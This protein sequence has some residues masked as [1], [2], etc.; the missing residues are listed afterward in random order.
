MKRVIYI[1]LPV[2]L[3][4]S[5]VFGQKNK[6]ANRPKSLN[7]RTEFIFNDTVVTNQSG[8]K[9]INLS[10]KTKYTDY[11]IFSFLKDT[12]YVDTSLTIEKH[13]AFN[14]LR[15]DHFGLLP[16]HNV[17]QTFNRMTYDFNQIR[18]IPDIGFTAKQFFFKTTEDIRY[19]EV[20]TPTSEIMFLTTLEQGQFLNSFFTLNFSR[21]MNA[22]IAYTGLRSLGKYRESLVSQGN[23]RTTFHYETKKRTYQVRGHLSTYDN[24]NEESG[25]LTTEALEA[26]IENDL[27]FSDRARLDVNLDETENFFKSSRFFFEHDFK[28]LSFKDSMEQKKFTILKIG[29]LFTSEKK[30]YEFRQNS[31]TDFIGSSNFSGSINDG[32]KNSLLRNTFFLEL[33]SKHILG[34]LRVK[35]SQMR[36][37]YGYDQIKDQNS[38][39][40]NPRLRGKATSLGAE[41]N[42]RVKQFELTADGEVIPGVDRL[43]GNNLSANVSYKRDSSFQ[44]KASVILNSKSP[45]FNFLLHQ[46]SY[47]EYNWENDFDKVKTQHLGIHLNSKWLTMLINITNIKNYPYF[48]ENSQP[49]QF[50]E[51]IVYLKAKASGDIRYK[52]LVLDNT[53]MYQN[54]REGSAVFRVPEFV[55]R[56]T[57]Y[58]DDYWFEGKPMKVQI[59]ATFNYFTKYNAN[60]YDPLLAEFI[61]QD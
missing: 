57:L 21:R 15:K 6:P 51:N 7:Q 23:F 49:K 52:N 44:I 56:S 17:G 54:V 42:A 50:L 13:Y 26:F 4:V 25:G 41:W 39:I 53:I 24:L 22:S 18:Q 31:A 38:G 61:L 35:S 29:H 11:K 55:T 1:I 16:F 46:S 36:Y 12:T 28:I 32:V 45:N 59:G 9:K 27:N 60:A 30:S 20:P 19:Y 5:S 2:L 40:T 3:A 14:F 43:S 8:T 10:A 58:Y 48:G 33:N 37:T 34:S 47:D